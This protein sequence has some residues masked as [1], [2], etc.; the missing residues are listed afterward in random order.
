MILAISK[1]VVGLLAYGQ[2][3][4]AAINK[5][6][7]LTLEKPT[8]DKPVADE[9]EVQ[10]VVVE[11][12]I[13]GQGADIESALVFTLKNE[14]GYTDH[15]LDKGGPTNKGITIG[16]L[17]EYLGRNATKDEVKN[18]DFETIKLIYKKCNYSVPH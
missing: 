12:H 14:G 4:L 1:L 16:R 10:R 7:A 8:V 5:F 17:S 13:D 6:E 18:L 2:Q 15:P 11:N 3:T 9:A